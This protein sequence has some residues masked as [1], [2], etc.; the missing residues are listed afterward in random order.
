MN[1]ITHT[2]RYQR[3]INQ[4]PK[5][6]LLRL[7]FTYTKEHS[8]AC[9]SFAFA[10]S[11]GFVSAVVSP[12][13][14][15]QT[16]TNKEE[17]TN[18]FL[19]VLGDST[20]SGKSD[21][22]RPLLT[23]GRLKDAGLKIEDF[24]LVSGNI[25]DTV[26]GTV[27]AL[28]DRVNTQGPGKATCGEVEITLPQLFQDKTISLVTISTEA[29]PYFNSTGADK[30]NAR[31]KEVSAFH[32]NSYDSDI[33]E[34]PLTKA[35]R[36]KTGFDL[37]SIR[38]MCTLI[39]GLTSQEFDEVKGDT[40]AANGHLPRFV[41]VGVDESF[42]GLPYI[43]YAEAQP[44]V[45]KE[46]ILKAVEKFALNL[47]EYRHVVRFNSN[48]PIVQ[49]LN[50]TFIDARNMDIDISDTVRRASIRGVVNLYRVAGLIAGCD[51]ME[52]VSDNILIALK[53]V[54]EQ[55]IMPFSV[56]A[57]NEGSNI[58][59]KILKSILWYHETNCQDPTVWEIKK[60]MTVRNSSE[61][62]KA[63][64]SLILSG[65]ITGYINHPGKMGEP[66]YKEYVNTP[67]HGA[68]YILP[69]W[70]AEVKA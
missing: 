65:G 38:A 5:D 3:L 54:F 7:C 56:E 63:L 33:I 59:K 4:L 62:T 39:F 40:S 35:A 6:N 28:V 42:E 27:E 34:V 45:S 66:S 25:Q 22:L 43:D 55:D 61:F 64:T 68:K 32:R 46:E 44:T 36:S 20:V 49:E 57:Q 48:S 51:L 15:I 69:D 26:Q 30:S 14:R 9:D 31:G 37:D 67:K 16:K 19:C 52:A 50:K 24:I 53:N 17:Q 58:E 29:G 8:A 23:S 10:A 13:V 1:D 18:L 41:F 47:K 2:G 60:K 11:L 12:F 21:A 70:E